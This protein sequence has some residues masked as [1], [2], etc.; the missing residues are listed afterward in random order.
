[1]KNTY[2]KNNV[3]KRN[4]NKIK[5][6]ITRNIIESELDIIVIVKKHNLFVITRQIQF[7]VSS[8]ALRILLPRKKNKTYGKLVNCILEN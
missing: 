5:L 2:F 6:N 4:I 7:F 8:L 1:M 3:I